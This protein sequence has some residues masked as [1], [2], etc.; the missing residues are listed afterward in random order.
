MYPEYRYHGFL[1]SQEPSE[2]DQ[3]EQQRAAEERRQKNALLVDV[4]E[5]EH[6]L[7]FEAEVPGFEQ[8]EIQTRLDGDYLTIEAQRKGE[9]FGG[10]FHRRE[11]KPKKL[12]RS[13]YLG[14]YAQSGDVQARLRNGLLTVTLQ[15]PAGNR[16]RRIEVP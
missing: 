15:K 5:D 1:H 10:F 9:D 14:H 11:R 4:K 7:Y 16:P 6:N 8:D 3:L 13:F 12:S 2:T